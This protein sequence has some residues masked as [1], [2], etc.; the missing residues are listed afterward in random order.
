MKRVNHQYEAHNGLIRDGHVELVE[1]TELEA[2]K[3]TP[4]KKG[5]QAHEVE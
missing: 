4:Q 1:L 5:H 3:E 2:Q